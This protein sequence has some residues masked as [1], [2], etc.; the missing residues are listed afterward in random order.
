M[1]NDE[2]KQRV[3]DLETAVDFINKTITNIIK[4]LKILHPKSFKEGG[5]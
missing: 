3:K 5:D 1:P 4:I 2:L